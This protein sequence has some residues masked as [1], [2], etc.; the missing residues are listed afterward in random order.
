MKKIYLSVTHLDI[1]ELPDELIE[2]IMKE[3]DTDNEK[4]AEDWAAES[5][6][7]E[8]L[9]DNGIQNYNDIEWEIIDE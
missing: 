8:Y 9:K 4:V 1:L 7:E 3:N 6:I 5:V 2:N